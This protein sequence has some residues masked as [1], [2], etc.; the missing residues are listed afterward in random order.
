MQQDGERLPAH[1]VKAVNIRQGDKGPQTNIDQIRHFSSTGRTVSQPERQTDNQHS[2]ADKG[3]TGRVQE[4]ANLQPAW[5]GGL[6][7]GGGGRAGE[8]ME[9]EGGFEEGV[10][11]E[12]QQVRWT[13]SSRQRIIPE[14]KRRKMGRYSSTPQSRTCAD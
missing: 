11:V 9:S 10:R 3:S 12:R 7:Q 6:R 4:I 14:R 2:H 8:M 5:Q 13:E 1:T